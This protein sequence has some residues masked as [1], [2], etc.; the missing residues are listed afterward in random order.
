M[1]DSTSS[2]SQANPIITEPTQSELE[3]VEALF[4]A[5]AAAPKTKQPEKAPEADPGGDASAANEGGEQEQEPDPET[6][7][8]DDLEQEENSEGVDYS[9][10]IPLSNGEKLTLGEL[11]DHYQAS[12]A[13]EVEMIEREN[14]VMQKYDEIQEMGQYMNIPPEVRQRI[15]QQQVEYLT[16]QHG[17]MLQAIPEWKDQAAFEKGRLL[18]H[19]LGK[20]YGVDLSKVA[21]HRVV[22]MLRD[23]STLKARIKGA[24]ESLKPI[25]PTEPKSIR[26]QPKTRQSDLQN[27][28]TAAQKSGNVADQLRAVD[29]LIKG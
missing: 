3:Q 12:N 27:A 15:A 26:Q 1:S 19:D 23:F 10:E 13:R 9:Q 25:K 21:D 14:K 6:G 29:M 24:R 17:K 20:E 11:K 8:T 7:H 28:V 5:P 16:E 18:I 22:K 2:T 4:N